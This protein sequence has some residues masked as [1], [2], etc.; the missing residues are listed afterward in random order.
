MKLK[1]PWSA[2]PGQVKINFP[3]YDPDQMS[4]TVFGPKGT[5][6]DLSVSAA[7]IN[8]PQA[9]LNSNVTS[10]NEESYNVPA[11][12]LVP[13][14][15]DQVKPQAQVVSPWPSSEEVATQK[16]LLK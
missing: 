13:N 3:P 6:P 10:P 5:L 2:K 12:S 1:W 15:G 9:Q 4:Q 14:P 11:A 16:N 7:S 8:N